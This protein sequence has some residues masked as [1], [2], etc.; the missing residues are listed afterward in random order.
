MEPTSNHECADVMQLAA[1]LE[2]IPVTELPQTELGTL[3]SDCCSLCQRLRRMERNPGLAGHLYRVCLSDEYSERELYNIM[4]AWEVV[5]SSLMRAQHP[6]LTPGRLKWFNRMLLD[7]VSRNSAATPGYTRVVP[8][9]VG[10]HIPAHA[11]DC[12]PLLQQL[13]DSVPTLGVGGNDFERTVLRA[14]IAHVRFVGIHPFGDG[15]GR[16]ARLLEFD[17]LLRGDIPRAAAHLLSNH[18]N[19]TRGEYER[20][21]A[22]ALRGD[23]ASFVAYAVR[24][25]RAELKDSCSIRTVAGNPD[26]RPAGTGRSAGPLSGRDRVNNCADS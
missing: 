9:R 16:T 6:K 5:N 20:Q 13:C 3:L 25:L 7:G 8:V 18:Y 1:R 11:A 23:V 4:H 21:L 15:N 2:S 19:R 12:E 17:L 14:L 22:A 26:R 24:G 10:Q